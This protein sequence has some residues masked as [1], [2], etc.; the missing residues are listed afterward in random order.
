M[1]EKLR[2]PQVEVCR[3]GKASQ[4]P[5]LLVAGGRQ[6]N[7][8]WLRGTADS[9]CAV[10]AVDKGAGNCRDAGL[11]PDLFVGDKDSADRMV[12]QWVVDAGVKVLEFPAEKDRTDLQ[13]ALS[14]A[15]RRFPD[16]RVLVTGGWGGRFDH[17]LSAVY[18]L[19]WSCRWGLSP[20]GMADEK[21]VLLLLR[22]RGR[23]ML[24]FFEL[25]FNLSLL[26]LSPRCRGV[27][28]TGVRWELHCGKLLLDKPYAVSNKVLRNEERK[29]ITVEVSLDEG[30]LG[31]YLDFWSEKK[32]RGL[33]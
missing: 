25:P 1:S 5:L 26:S 15:A 12:L 29:E 23:S 22:G 8:M 7:E 11:I 9:C 6:S 18:S 27:C 13:L 21:E 2:L 31:V 17:L 16:G 20:W 19:V 3:E 32:N 14:E 24:R 4:K 28:V 10:W 30:L 33:S